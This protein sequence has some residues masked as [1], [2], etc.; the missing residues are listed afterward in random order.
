ML[1]DDLKI[2]DKATLPVMFKYSRKAKTEQILELLLFFDV[3]KSV[4]KYL[5]ETRKQTS[6]ICRPHR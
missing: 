1:S 2:N 6:F 3:L 4:I 5:L